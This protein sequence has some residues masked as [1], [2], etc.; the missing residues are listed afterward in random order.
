MARRSGSD[1]LLSLAEVGWFLQLPEHTVRRLCI[2]GGLPAE[3][4]GRN[5]QLRASQLEPFLGAIARRR[6]D[7]VRRGEWAIPLPAT[8]SGKPAPLTATAVD[9][10]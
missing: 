7:Q 3:R 8:R 10:G 2:Q 4:P 6:L 9:R 1:L 5:W